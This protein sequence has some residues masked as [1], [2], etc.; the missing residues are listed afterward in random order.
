MAVFL[1]PL[2]LSVSQ[3]DKL[4][5]EFQFALQKSPL[6]KGNCAQSFAM[7]GSTCHILVPKGP[8]DA[9]AWLESPPIVAVQPG[10]L[11]IPGKAGSC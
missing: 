8:A 4:H 5:R 9:S 7:A 2:L 1:P 6:W 3:M 10:A 11:Q